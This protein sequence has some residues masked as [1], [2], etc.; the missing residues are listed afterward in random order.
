MEDLSG[1]EECIKMYTESDE[2]IAA[3]GGEK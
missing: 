3:T 1:I 2:K